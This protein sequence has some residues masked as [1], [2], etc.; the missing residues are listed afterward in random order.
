MP[1][2]EEVTG[3]HSLSLPTEAVNAVD[4]Q[5]NIEPIGPS[6]RQLPAESINFVGSLIKEKTTVLLHSADA[7]TDPTQQQCNLESNLENKAATRVSSANLSSIGQ[8]Q[9]AEKNALLIIEDKTDCGPNTHSTVTLN[10]LNTEKIVSNE[11]YPMKINGTHSSSAQDKV[12]VSLG[13]DGSNY[14]GHQGNTVY[15]D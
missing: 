8:K 5:P 9:S 14:N 13:I 3:F 7:V 12:S 15:E 6:N 2:E 4:T 1:I 11:V 10:N